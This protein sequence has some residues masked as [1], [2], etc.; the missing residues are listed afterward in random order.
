M[1]ELYELLTE[2]SP[3]FEEARKQHKRAHFNIK[4]VR[5]TI[6]LLGLPDPDD[7]EVQA[8]Q[9]EA[10][11]PKSTNEQAINDTEPTDEPKPAADQMTN[12]QIPN[13]APVHGNLLPSDIKDCPGV[14][15][16]LKKLALD[17]DGVADLKH[18]SPMLIA[19]GLSK[20][21]PHNLI[22]NLNT[23]L[24]NSDDWKRVGSGLFRYLP[25]DH[26]SE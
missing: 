3:K 14:D 16:A 6:K 23:R 22:A 10:D 13:D 20:S 18:A 4:A 11:Q 26:V 25:V 19:A 5:Q 7:P 2:L 9:N 15:A 12:D 1:K 24:V 17:N 8:N 21:Q